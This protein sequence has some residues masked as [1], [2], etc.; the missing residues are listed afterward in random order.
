L[1]SITDYEEEEMV[2]YRQELEEHTQRTENYFSALQKKF[3]DKGIKV[4]TCIVANGSAVKDIVDCA[5][6]ENVDLIAMASHGR[7]GLPR[8]F[9]GSVTAGVLHLVDRPLL[10]IR[11]RDDN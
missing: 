2:L 9:Y 5:E 8:A 1:P 11:S 10:I 4:K 3:R 6:R 7:T